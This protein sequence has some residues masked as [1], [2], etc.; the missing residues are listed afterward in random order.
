MADIAGGFS[1]AQQIR[2]VAGLRW[3]IIRHSFN[4]KNRRLDMLGLICSGVFGALFVAG[5]TVAIYIGTEY[6]LQNHLEQFL[7]LLFLA[8]FLWWQ[9]FPILL[10]GFAPQFTFRSLLRFP[11]DL[12]AFY[13]IG[14]SYGLADSAALAALVWMAAMVAAA[15]V[16]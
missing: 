2:L 13:L 9:L 10:A 12:S 1:L 5:V 16:A 4:N 14:L 7:A 11:L 15:V 8:L 3:R 6:L